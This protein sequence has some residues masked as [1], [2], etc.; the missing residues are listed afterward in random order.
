MLLN[1]IN[2]SKLTTKTLTI[3]HPAFCVT[4][5]MFIFNYAL[6]LLMTTSSS[7]EYMP[8]VELLFYERLEN[9]L[10]SERYAFLDS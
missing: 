2:V 3:P 4:F 9:V 6:F 8:H 1:K 5:W 10:L 7:Q